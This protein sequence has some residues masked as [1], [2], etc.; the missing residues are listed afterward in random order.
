MHTNKI[1]HRD[2]KGTTCYALFFNQFCILT[3]SFLVF[4]GANLLVTKNNVLKI[5]DWGLARSYH[6]ET[7]KYE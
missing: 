1:L 5:A 7:Q 2:I 4:K 6:S 3:Y